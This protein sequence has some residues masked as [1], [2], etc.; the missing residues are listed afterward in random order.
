MLCQ[1]VVVENKS[2]QDGGE[3]IIFFYLLAYF[4]GTLI[5]IG[6][7][8]YREMLDCKRQV[9]QNPNWT[10]IWRNTN[11]A[12]PGLKRRLTSH[13]SCM[14]CVFQPFAPNTYTCLP[15]INQHRD[16]ITLIET[17]IYF[18]FYLNINKQNL[19]LI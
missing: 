14:K 17:F 18:I 10:Q 11:P 16:N 9:G 5:Y 1:G 3:A 4:L 13:H 19:L 6:L 2:G 7:R 8:S 15:I 12:I